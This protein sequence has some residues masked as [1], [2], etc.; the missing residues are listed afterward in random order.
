[1]LKNFRFDVLLIILICLI[2]I[3][4]TTYTFQLT[5]LDWDIY[6]AKFFPGDKILIKNLLLTF[7]FFFVFLFFQDLGNRD[8]DNDK[9]KVGWRVFVITLVCLFLHLIVKFSKHYPPP[10]N[11]DTWYNILNNFNILIAIVFCGNCFFYFKSLI[12]FQKSVRINFV[13]KTFEYMI[14]GTILLTIFNVDFTEVITAISLGIF[15]CIALYLSTQ[16]RWVAFL[17]KAQKI[18]TIFRFLVYF[19]TFVLIIQ[20]FFFE[21]FSFTRSSNTDLLVMDC[22]H[23]FF[24][25]SAFTFVLFYSISSILILLFNLPTSS[26]FEQKINNSNNYKR[27]SQ[28]LYKDRNEDGIY[29]I[30]L[31]ISISTSQANFGYIYL[32]TENKKILNHGT[33]I[34]QEETIDLHNFIIETFS[35]VDLYTTQHVKDFTNQTDQFPYLIEKGIKSGLFIPIIVKD[36]LLGTLA[37]FKTLENG[38]E[39]ETQELITSYALQSS[40]SIENKALMQKAI[41]NER[42]QQELEIAKTVKT[43]LLTATINLGEKIDVAV[44]SKSADQVGGD[45]YD[46]HQ[47]SEDQYVV[48]LGDVS[49]HGTSAAFNMAQLKGIFQSA[50]RNETNF[51]K[52]PSIINEALYYCLESESFVTMSFFLVDNQKQEL[53]HFRCGHNPS[54]FLN[55]K[56]IK[57]MR[58]SGIGLGMIKNEKFNEILEK[59]VLSTKNKEILLCYTD[60]FIEAQNIHNEHFGLEK[61][62]EVL[63]N[64]QEKSSQEIINSLDQTLTSFIYG[65]EQVDDYSCL[66]IKF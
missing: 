36:K 56:G 14:F 1:M 62:E 49:G 31:E 48:V 2:W 64:T 38:F 10:I 15:A 26:A 12:L 53:T 28:T 33:G 39:N 16:M 22:A 25:L 50:V 41:E 24:L 7:F 55:E 43:K 44:L 47:I 54:L 46:Y 6:I 3:L 65:T 29:E 66:V 20:N 51:E 57:R 23:N 45:F 60:G 35:K 52:Y 17:S 63:E 18:R 59:E 4:L 37:L 19:I 61:I 8:I 34:S 27:L 21:S 13:W 42:Y 40:I 58:S 9:N 30:L 11:I 5:S 32:P